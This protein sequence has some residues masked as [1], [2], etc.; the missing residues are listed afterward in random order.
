VTILVS[1][2]GCSERRVQNS[3]LRLVPASDVNWLADAQLKVASTLWAVTDRS[4]G[5]CSFG[6]RFRR[7]YTGQAAE[8]QSVLS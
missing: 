5:R 1:G 6:P 3:Q 8:L 7:S 4:V 2:E